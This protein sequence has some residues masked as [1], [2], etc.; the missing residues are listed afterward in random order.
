MFKKYLVAFIAYIIP[1]YLLEWYGMH[2]GWWWYTTPSD[3]LFS[4]FNLS[5]TFLMICIVTVLVEFNVPEATPVIFVLASWFY[6]IAGTYL[7]YNIPSLFSIL[8]IHPYF[9]VFLYV[10][11]LGISSIAFCITFLLTRPKED[12]YNF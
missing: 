6:V 8:A 4:M 1:T 12:E 2:I 10:I 11:R 7:D 5:I 9:D 3:L